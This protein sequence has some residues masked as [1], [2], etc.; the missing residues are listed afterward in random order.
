MAMKR[1]RLYGGRAVHAVDAM[2]DGVGYATG[3]GIYL[4]ADAKNNWM[5]DRTPVTCVRCKARRKR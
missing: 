4:T 1:V 5:A 3:C 2:D